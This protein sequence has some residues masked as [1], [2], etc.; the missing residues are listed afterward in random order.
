MVTLPD[1]STI[2]SGNEMRALLFSGGIDSTAIA[3]QLK[4]EKLLFIDY[5]QVSAIGELRAARSIAKAIDREL[6]VRSVSLRKFG[7]G[8]MAGDLSASDPVPEFWPYRNQAL[9]TVAAMA[10]ADLEV[11]SIMIGTVNGDGDRHADGSVE[12]VE[13][14]NRLLEMQGGPKL[15]APAIEVTSEQLIAGA[16]VPQSVLGW[17]F[18]CH[19]G[20]WACGTCAGCVKHDEIMQR[21]GQEG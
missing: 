19:T 6:D 10:Y 9:V 8:S 3:W 1:A 4:P 7:R 2:Q 21:L 14:M 12:F 15:E 11:S 17:T 5:G 18:S 16:R 20:E 13:T